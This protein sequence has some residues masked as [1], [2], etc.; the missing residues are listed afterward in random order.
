MLTHSTADCRYDHSIPEKD[1]FDLPLDQGR[2]QRTPSLA[3][4]ASASS[5]SIQ[6]IVDMP[7][8]HQT[9]ANGEDLDVN[10]RDA[11]L[12]ARISELETQVRLLKADVDPARKNVKEELLNE[13]LERVRRENLALKIEFKCISKS[14][15]VLR[16]DIERIKTQEKTLKNNYRLLDEKNLELWTE[17]RS[18]VDHLETLG[19]GLTNRAQEMSQGVRDLGRFSAA[20]AHGVVENA[21]QTARD[22][23]VVFNH[24][25]T[26]HEHAATHPVIL[27]DEG[28]SNAATSERESPPNA[29]T[30]I[31]S[32]PEEAVSCAKVNEDCAATTQVGCIPSTT[33]SVKYPL[34]SL[35]MPKAISQ[36]TQSCGAVFGQPQKLQ[37]LVSPSTSGSKVLSSPPSSLFGACVLASNSPTSSSAPA[38][39]S[40]KAPEMEVFACSTIFQSACSLFSFEE[41]R[42]KYSRHLSEVP[43]TKVHKWTQ[44]Q[45]QQALKETQGGFQSLKQQNNKRSLGAEGNVSAAEISRV[46]STPASQGLTASKKPKIAGDKVSGGPRKMGGERVV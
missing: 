40:G 11:K 45:L 44:E 5:G 16:K 23:N 3:S 4:Q 18:K 19:K 9:A 28:G 46:K 13:E 7:E 30:D 29:A 6:I 31:K 41:D 22:D 17:F 26:S 42:V 39:T 2:Q 10:L 34:E 14:E 1:T 27:D 38:S 33:R 21:Y 35:A 12:K 36:G 25:S 32:N 15:E 24:E 43:N 8:Q 37:P 20:V